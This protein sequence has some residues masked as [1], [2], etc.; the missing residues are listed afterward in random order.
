MN[1]NDKDLMNDEFYE[2]VDAPRQERCMKMESR[3]LF[4]KLRLLEDDTRKDLGV[5]RYGI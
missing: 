5:T 2:N 4:N 1:Y 3:A